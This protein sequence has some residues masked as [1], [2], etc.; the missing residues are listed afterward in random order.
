M[1]DIGT[2]IAQHRAQFVAELCEWLRIPGISAQAEHHRDVRASAE[3]LAQA[4]KDAGFSRAEIWDD[5]P[6]LPAVFAEWPGA[7][8]SAPTVL[9]YA[10]HDVQPA[11]EAADWASAPFEP[12]VD[13]DVV[14]GRGA[15]DDK[16]QILFHLLAA[17]AHAE[18]AGRTAPA[19]T[20][21]LLIEGEEESGSPNLTTLLAAHRND[22]D[23]DLIVVTDSGMISAEVPS[24]LTG[25]RGLVAATVTFT[26]PDRD[27]HSGLFGGAV[28]NP[29]TAL[30][31]M[32]ASLLDEN[33]HVQ[34]PGFYDDV[35]ELTAQ[36]RTL[37]AQL[38]NDDAAFLQ[39]A[40]S[41]ALHG[42][43]GYSTAE[44]IGA[45]PTADVNGIRAGHYG[46]GHMTI[47]PSTAIAKLT[48]RLVANQDPAAVIKS[49]TKYI[50]AQAPAGIDV[51]VAWAG[52]GVPPCR[53]A[54]D[55]PAYTAAAQAISDVFDGKP[56]LPTREG[57][58]GPEA[59]LQQTLGAQ[60]VFIGFALP[61]D[62]IHGPNEKADVAML[63]KGA[64]A[65]ARL[66]ARLGDLG[67]ARVRGG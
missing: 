37:F 57:G 22:L 15:S 35:L 65:C 30:A 44:R 60:L 63:L 59:V 64:E 62:G 28:P 66:W 55:T 23:C 12:V 1:T 2:Y 56:V 34:V 4:A 24:M 10:H 7:E 32:I 58:S 47:I 8:P 20:L 13:G 26:G 14:R 53:V 18:T 27:V 19:V 52:D 43:I 42:E 39:A 46:E 67:R 33:G 49:V 54:V 50:A 5:G 16:G 31:R 3:W 17:K 25:L 38:P 21:K 45:R 61:D 29:A 51:D 11:G 48:F 6:W 41:R 36:E 9:V 40:G